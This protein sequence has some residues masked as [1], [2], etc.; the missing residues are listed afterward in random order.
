MA[1]SIQNLRGQEAQNG[2]VLTWIN[3]RD[4][5]QGILI[6]IAKDSEFTMA[7]RIFVFPPTVSS[8]TLQV[9]VGTW[10]FRAGSMEGTEKSGKV[11][12][13]GIYDISIQK[14][15]C[16]LPAESKASF[17]VLHTQSV[18]KGV[19]LF[20]DKIKPNYYFMEYTT[21]DTFEAS[22]TKTIYAK[23]WK[24]EGSVLCEPL[25]PS[26]TYSIR[27]SSLVLDSL[28]LPSKFVDYLSTWI[29]LKGK[30]AQ[31]VSKAFTPIDV[32]ISAAEQVLLREAKERP[33]RFTSTADYTRYLALKEK[34]S[35][36][37]EKV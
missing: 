1:T 30:K 15:T 24:T 13:T 35:S 2:L 10:F 5:F 14:G 36:A 23:D 20:T 34:T 27:I 11:V 6:E 21:K 25:D 26:L 33:L 8:C 29:V 12:W 31:Q 16:M 19:K 18:D 32:S 4:D 37:K 22:Q 9:G 17:S 3:L 28:H 7:S